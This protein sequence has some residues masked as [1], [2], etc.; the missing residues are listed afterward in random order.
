MATVYFGSYYPPDGYSNNG[1]WNDV[2]Q[3]FSD[4]G[5]QGEDYLYPAT[6]L[7]RSPNPATDTVEL[8]QNVTSGSGTYSGPVFGSYYWA[9]DAANLTLSGAIVY[10]INN[11]GYATFHRGTFSGNLTA[12]RAFRIGGGTFTNLSS[13]SS[14][15]PS[16]W[17]LYETDSTGGTTPN[18]LTL[19]AGFS[20][21]ASGFSI[22]RS[23]T[24]DFPIT[25]GGVNGGS[26]SVGPG[27]LTKQYPVFTRDM[28]TAVTS[29]T[30]YTVQGWTSAAPTVPTT[31]STVFTNTATFTIGTPTKPGYITCYDVQITRPTI[32]Y[33]AKVGDYDQSV[34]SYWN[35]KP[36]GTINTPIVL[37]KLTILT[38]QGLNTGRIYVS[39]PYTY[40]VT[41]TVA[42]L[43]NQQIDP[44][45]IPASYDF[46]LRGSTFNPTINLTLTQNLQATSE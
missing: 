1:N 3:W 40:I 7:G 26:I 39:G 43:P 22:E 2:N 15:Q 5:E 27:Y 42:V 6:P 44:N 31:L 32:L 10:N 13:F 24:I 23:M 17:R 34:F 19:P 46:G 37:D 36:S 9:F 45:G 29:C 35:N 28:S 12:V 25:F 21:N 18:T 33:T 11:G 16:D 41:A 20:I 14:T 8:M 30:N 4:Q 38:V